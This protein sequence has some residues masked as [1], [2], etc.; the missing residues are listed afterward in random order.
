MRSCAK[1]RV[2]IIILTIAVS[3]LYWLLSSNSGFEN[4]MTEYISTNG[5]PTFTAK[6]YSYVS[7][8]LVGVKFNGVV[9][10]YSP[11]ELTGD[12]IYLV[13]V[14]DAF[15]SKWISTLETVNP[16]NGVRSLHYSKRSLFGKEEL[17]VVEISQSGAVLSKVKIN[18]DWFTVYE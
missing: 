10:A 3:F 12:R 6:H 18:Y 4:S 1:C 11:V 9:T 14:K 2:I 13:Y 7:S 15:A 17:I 5:Y 8:K 16:A